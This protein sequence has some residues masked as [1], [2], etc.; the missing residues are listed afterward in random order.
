M[1]KMIF[2]AKL[3]NI[4]KVLDFV[5]NEL[6]KINCPKKPIMQI[7]IAIDE[8]F[9]NIARYAYCPDIGKATVCIEVKEDPAAIV[10]YFIDNG[11]FYDPL[12]KKDPDITLSADERAIG[13]LGIFM[14]KNMMDEISYEYKDGQNILK[15][16]KNI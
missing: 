6:V 4:S 13:G 8:I 5:R 9:S 16:K 10:L 1:K 11:V 3:E 15:I 12:E 7:E 2:D 14:V